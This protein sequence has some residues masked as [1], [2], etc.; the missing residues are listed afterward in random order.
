MLA[1]RLVP[2][3]SV[4]AD[5]P[6]SRAQAVVARRL[7]DAGADEILIDLGDALNVDQEGS[8]RALRAIAQQTSVPLLVLGASDLS[9]AS[10]LVEAG[11]DKLVIPF[12]KGESW[13]LEAARRWGATSIVALLEAGTAAAEL[14]ALACNAGAGEVMVRVD[15]TESFEPAAI[16]AVSDATPVPVLVAGPFGAVEHVR[17]A[18][19]DARADAVVVPLDQVEAAGGVA[20][21][22]LYLAAAGIV[23]RGAS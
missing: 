1:K 23:V 12:R 2:C 7:D 22:K 11:A 21:L 5:E 20:E 18:L 3:L 8:L 15:K 6:G 19:L 10:S 14:A 13:T 17:Q 4:P 9:S 16:R